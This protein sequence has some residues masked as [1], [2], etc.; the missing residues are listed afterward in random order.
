MDCGDLC[1]QVVTLTAIDN[2]TGKGH[3]RVQGCN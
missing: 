2:Q 3:H 1:K